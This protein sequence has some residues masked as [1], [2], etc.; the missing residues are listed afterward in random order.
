MKWVDRKSGHDCF[1]L[2]PRS[3]YITWGG[4][5][6]WS[7]NCFKETGEENIEVAKLSHV[8]WLDVRGKFNMADLSPG[9]AYE[10]IYVVKLTK[11]ASGWELPI[12]LKLSL[13]NG[14]VRERQVVLLQKPVGQWI[15][16]NVGNFLTKK[17]D[18]GEVCFDVFEHGGHWKNGLIVKGA[19]LRPKY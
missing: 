16:L 18:K 4:H 3:L 5:E 19:I 10:V 1:M 2:F 7:W 6:Y 17:G 12:T 14:E 8:C 11:G 13:P 9:T 15:E